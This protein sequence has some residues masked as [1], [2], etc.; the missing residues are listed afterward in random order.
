MRVLVVDDSQI[1]G[2][3][4]ASA[5]SQL[6]HACTTVRSGDDAYA[7]LEEQTF[8]VVMTD[9]M[10]PGMSGIEL[11]ERIRSMPER[12][13]VY[14]VLLTSLADRRHGLAAVRAGADAF[15]TK[16]IDLVSIEMCLITAERVS[17]MQRQLERQRRMVEQDNVRLERQ[18]RTD[19]LTGLGNR[20]RLDE[21]LGALTA[22]VERY[23][24][25][26]CAVMADLDRFKAYNDRFG[27]SPGDQALKTVASILQHGCRD[28]DAIYRYGGEEMTILLP[29]QTLATAAVV[30]ERLRAAVQQANIPHPDNAPHGV[31]TV[32]MGVAELTAAASAEPASLLRRADE[33]LYQAKRAG[34]NCITLAGTPA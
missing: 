8:D 9:W 21:D 4:L 26:A 16:P 10:M 28:A 15:L 19:P 5:V 25:S 30:V 13:Y 27:H 29:H 23:G 12:H 11:C 1:D 3:V 24:T 2:M 6:G 33:A 32:S 31:V 20:Q 22:H 14:T 18:V 17:F 7:T 34:R